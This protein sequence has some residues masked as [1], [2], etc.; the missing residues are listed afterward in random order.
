MEENDVQKKMI[1]FGAGNI[2]RSFIGQLFSRSGYEIIL[3]EN[4]R[5]VDSYDKEAVIQEIVNADIIATAVGKHALPQIVPVIAQ[6]L[7]S[8][9]KKRKKI[10]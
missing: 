2:G 5:A 4:I 6:G 7:Q 8:R 3:I 1:Q 9:Y 10:L